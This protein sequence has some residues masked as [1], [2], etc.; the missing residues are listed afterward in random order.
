MD[1]RGKYLLNRFIPDGEK[2][3]M[4]I[5]KIGTVLVLSQ[6]PTYTK[7]KANKEDLCFGFT[8]T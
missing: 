4:F 5:L 2:K 1:V 8:V 6:T 3:H 7:P